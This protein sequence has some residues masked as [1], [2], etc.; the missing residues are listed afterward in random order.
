LLPWTFVRK[1]EATFA[2]RRRKVE[3]RYCT[4]YLR[5]ED[6]DEEEHG[7][8]KRVRRAAHARHG[9]GMKGQMMSLVGGARLGF[10]LKDI[11]LRQRVRVL[12]R[13]RNNIEQQK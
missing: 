5:C 9:A 11:I 13:V 4:V 2:G 7:L 6:E 3:A 8:L 10:S 12:V 1:R